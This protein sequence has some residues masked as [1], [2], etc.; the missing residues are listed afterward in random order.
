MPHRITFVPEL[1]VV[2]ARFSGEI[3][4]PE[5]E[6][7]LDEVTREPWFHSHLKL[8]A[9]FRGCST[10]MSGDDVH[11]FATYAKRA[12]VAWGDTKWAI[13]AS[14]D[15]IYGLSRIYMAITAE[16]HVQTHVFRSA[17]ESDDWLGLGV[18]ID[19]ALKRAA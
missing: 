7:A 11:T 16:Y 3:S 19:E 15:L 13:L 2:V 14:S 6:K 17:Q 4:L 5:L 10:A 1:E 8:I 18:G 9:D 12:D